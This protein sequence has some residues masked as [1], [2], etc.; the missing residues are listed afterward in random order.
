MLWLHARRGGG[1]DPR[2]LGHPYVAAHTAVTQP[3]QHF[4]ARNAAPS[5]TTSK[6][7]VDC[8]TLVLRA[9]PPPE[10]ALEGWSQRT[11]ASGGTGRQA[12]KERART[13]TMRCGAAAPP[14]AAPTRAA[15]RPREAPAASAA[16]L[17]ARVQA[18]GA[19]EDNE[20][21]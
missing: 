4:Q 11:P 21:V 12:K 10:N 14:A 6:A 13:S 19:N 5:A 17:S 16:E 8:P 2:P 1:G 20:P 15:A 7:G 3:A 9:A 18:S